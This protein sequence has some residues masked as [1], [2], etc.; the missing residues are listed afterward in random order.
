MNQEKIGK[1]I[2]TCRKKQNLTQEELANN[3]GITS[4][5]VSKWECGKGL[6]DASIMLDL[7]QILNITVND[8]LSGEIVDKSSYQKKLEENIIDTIDYSNKKVSQK[9][10][11]IFKMLMLFGLILIFIAFTIYP[12]ESS[13]GKVLSITGLIISTIGFANINKIKPLIKRLFLSIS[14]FIIIFTLL[15]FIDYSNVSL[16]KVPPRFSYL[17]ETTD[18]IIMYKSPLCNVYRLNRNTK[19]EYYIIDTK[20]IYTIN[21]IPISPFNRDKSGIDNII[22]YKNKYVGNNS[23]TNNLINNLP[24]SEY[25]YVIE[26]NSTNLEL[27]IHYHI[28][29]WYIN[30]NYYLEKSLLYN[31][32]SLFA[33]IDNINKITFTFSGNT[34]TVTKTQVQEL[35]PN[36]NDIISDNIN[37]NNF[38]KYL[39]NKI[40]NNSFIE[41]IFKKIFIN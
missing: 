28:T 5:A 37:K 35:Y 39:E 18:K 1:F 36:F 22:K 8:L 6:P 38:N 30:N 23:N 29:D 40:N 25:G 3:L 32:V 24:L 2:A 12:S 7:C 9:N 26:I 31:T 14:Y 17:I 11:L 19:N 16:N 10:K 27:T 41:Y 4:K 20:K 13:W 21:N 34:Y 15:I 33:L